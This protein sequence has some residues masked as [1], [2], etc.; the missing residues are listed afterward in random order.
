MRIYEALYDE[1]PH[2]DHSQVFHSD[3]F[4]GW[5]KEELQSVLD[6]CENYS[7]AANPDA[8][9]SDYL[10]FR[11]KSKQEGVQVED[12]DIRGGLEKIQP[13]KIDIKGTISPENV[14]GIPELLQGSC[15]GQ[16]IAATSTTAAIPGNRGG[17]QSQ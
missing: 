6:N 3:Y 1:R 12:E 17:E 15:T 16:L 5:D 2:N 11:G 4:S 9:C 8:F 10:T 7:D 14:T 13:D